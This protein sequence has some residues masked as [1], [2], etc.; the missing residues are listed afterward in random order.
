M[1]FSSVTKNS[2]KLYEDG[3]IF[4]I[5]DQNQPLGS[6]L[7]Q[8]VRTSGQ[9]LAV[10]F[11]GNNITYAQIGKSVEKTAGLLYSIGVRKGDVVALVIPNCP[12]HLILFYA[13]TM[14]GAIV[15]EHNPLAP[16]QQLRQQLENHGARLVIAWENSTE[17]IIP[18]GD[19]HDRTILAVDITKAIPKRSQFLLRLPLRAARKQRSQLRAKVPPGVQLFDRLLA[20]ARAL[21]ATAFPEVDPDDVAVL[22]HT[23]GTT[24]S[25]KA[26]EITH[27]NLLSNAQQCSY[28]CDKVLGDK[29][30]VGAVLPFFHAFGLTLSMIYAVKMT[31]L[32]VMLPKFDPDMMLAAHNRHPLS[33]FVGVPPMFDRIEKR[34]TE[35][36][37]NLRSIKLAISGAMSLS[38]EIAQRW[39]KATGGVLIEGYGMTEASPVIAG[40]PPTINRRPG[41]IGIPLPS[42]DVRIADPENPEVDV[43]PGEVGELLVRGPQVFRG[44]FNDPEETDNAKFGDYLRTGDL[45]RQEDG[46]LVLADRQKEIIISN[47][48]NIYPSEVER[49]VRGMPGVIDVA[50]VG[51]DN[52]SAGEAVVAALVLEPGAQID[53]EQVRKWTADRLPRYAMPKQITIINDLPRSQIGKV[54]RRVVKENLTSLG[55]A[56]AQTADMLVQK[57]TPVAESVAESFRGA[58]QTVQRLVQRTDANKEQKDTADTRST[59][60][61]V[62]KCCNVPQ[63]GQNTDSFVSTKGKGEQIESETDSEAQ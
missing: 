42:T 55:A 6:L 54:L 5:S 45:V 19:L 33:F 4:E 31:S 49:A 15:A 36:K 38:G 30:T 14:L 40:N 60:K 22:L 52:G 56:T 37:I 2:H 35:R 51:I 32:Q 62:K 8:A 27:R 50:V 18:D 16:P 29:V 59:G 26:V 53:L 34:A 41:T 25:P 21:P 13:I 11:L 48:F 44:Y 43:P 63:E 47:G 58:A 3:V 39:E 61:Q 28:W 7:Q 9:K 57:A 17:A 46:F 24:G 12:Q 1:E 23:G 20:G 10:D